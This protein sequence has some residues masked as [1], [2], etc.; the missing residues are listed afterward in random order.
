MF[1][2]QKRA[3]KFLSGEITVEN[4]VTLLRL[5]DE[6]RAEGLQRNCIAFLM[7]HIHQTVRLGEFEEHRDWASLEVLTCLATILGSQWE[8][9]LREVVQRAK[10]E[11]S[12]IVP[13]TDTQPAIPSPPDSPLEKALRSNP[14]SPK[15][16]SLVA[17]EEE[18][19]PSDDDAVHDHSP[20]KRTQ[21]LYSD[22]FSDRSEGVC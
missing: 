12:S 10:L 20:L 17:D 19:R 8:E 5:A 15:R 13:C 2:L 3:E 9:S 11:Q 4:V 7:Q 6:A 21:V 16:L 18:P 14:G 1:E 22:D